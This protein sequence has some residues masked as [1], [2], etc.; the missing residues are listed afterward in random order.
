MPGAA[1]PTEWRTC[2][3]EEWSWERGEKEESFSL[4]GPPCSHSLPF[5]SVFLWLF[6]FLSLSLFSS[7]SPFVVSV[8]LCF[9][10]CLLL[11]SLRGAGLEP[12]ALHSDLSS[13]CFWL[14]E[15]GQVTSP[16]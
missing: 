1:I 2:T 15:L 7:V 14:C 8:S 6:L 10:L 5:L 9:P 12:D 13:A 3:T 11:V 16:L 4:P